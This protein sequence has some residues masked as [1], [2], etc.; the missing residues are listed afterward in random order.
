MLV[1]ALPSF[2]RLLSPLG[3]SLSLV[4]CLG[5]NNTTTPS[6][7]APTGTETFQSTLSVKG[8]SAREFIQP[9]SGSVTV[10][11]DSLF[12]GA[13]VGVGLGTPDPASAGCAISLSMDTLGGTDELSTT[14]DAGTYCVKIFDEGNVTQVS[15]FTITIVHQ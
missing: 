13:L 7:P 6:L 14:L 15:T 8:S 9:K 11:L 4:V 5:C 10:T 12:P 1:T 3:V 2:R